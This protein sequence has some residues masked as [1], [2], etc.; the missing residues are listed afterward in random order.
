MIS[1]FSSIGSGRERKDWTCVAKSASVRFAVSAS[2]NWGFEV[3]L[4]CILFEVTAPVGKSSRFDFENCD[5]AKFMLEVQF[6]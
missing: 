1:R 4:S 5:F 6:N 2:T 3:A